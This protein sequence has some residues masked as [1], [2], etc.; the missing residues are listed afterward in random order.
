M[1]R[2]SLS[3]KKN[4]GEGRRFLKPFFS[5]SLQSP[6]TIQIVPHFCANANLLSMMSDQYSLTIKSCRLILK[7]I[8][9][10]NQE[11]HKPIRQSNKNQKNHEHSLTN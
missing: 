7:Y 9:R 10:K 4:T 3:E 8:Q 11:K 6:S 5:G 1:L 2:K